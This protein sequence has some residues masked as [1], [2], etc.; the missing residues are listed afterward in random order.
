MKPF[1]LFMELLDFTPNTVLQ[2]FPGS[3]AKDDRGR[4][5]VAVIP[6]QVHPGGGIGLA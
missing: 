6:E 5:G 1:G 2:A 3:R 4:S